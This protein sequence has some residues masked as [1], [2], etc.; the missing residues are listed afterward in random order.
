MMSINGDKNRS[1]SKFVYCNTK[2]I[3]PVQMCVV[4]LKPEPYAKFFLK[5]PAKLVPK[6]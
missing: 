6:F 4:P 2:R 3:V 1:C 5:N